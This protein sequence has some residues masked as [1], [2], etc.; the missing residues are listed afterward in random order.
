[1]SRGLLAGMTDY[2]HQSFSD[3]I[4]DIEQ[5]IKSL[6]ETQ[7]LLRD[8]ID[9][10]DNN[11]YWRNVD[12]NFLTHVAYALKFYKTSEIELKEI[13]EDILT[14]EVQLNH[15]VRLRSM[16]TTASNLNDEYGQ[17]WHKRYSKPKD[18][19][20]SD[21]QIVEHLFIWSRYGC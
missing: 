2:T 9:T 3:M 8:H 12:S 15:I 18:Y 16:A 6:Q 7:E 11:G 4:E 19:G 10:L 1:M 20:N 5:W 13:L 21:F 17:V 14:D